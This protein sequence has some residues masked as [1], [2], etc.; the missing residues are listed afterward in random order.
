MQVILRKGQMDFYGIAGRSE[1][2]FCSEKLLPLLGFSGW[3]RPHS[4]TLTV[5]KTRPANMRGWLEFSVRTYVS[6]WSAGRVEVH[7]CGESLTGEAVK[8]MIARKLISRK[9]AESKLWVRVC[10]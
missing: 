10:K 7:I 4:I 2:M 8:W 1:R 6:Y 5:Q 9:T 3:S